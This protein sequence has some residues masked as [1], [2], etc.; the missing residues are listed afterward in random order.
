ML[1][2]IDVLDTFKTCKNNITYI[3]SVNILSS[4]KIIFDIHS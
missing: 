2:A 3:Y 4:T 1:S